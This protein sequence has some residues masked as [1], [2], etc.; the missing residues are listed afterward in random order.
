M[1]PIQELKTIK[2]F[3]L[4]VWSQVYWP[5]GISVSRLAN[6]MI[7][8]FG[9]RTKAPVIAN[10]ESLLG[11][12]LIGRNPRHIVAMKCHGELDDPRMEDV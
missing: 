3:Y 9:R 6:D 2:K 4:S 12:E 5:C 11:T 7:A 8:K 10:V 1:T